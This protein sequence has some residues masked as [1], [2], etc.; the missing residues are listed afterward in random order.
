MGINPGRMSSHQ[1]FAKELG[2]SFPL[3]VDAD[4][5]VA[6]SYGALKEDGVGIQRTV[7]IVD[8]QGVVRYIKQG[9]PPD[10][11]LLEAIKAF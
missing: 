2:L 11:E 1:R 10:A 4:R 3:L 9:M 5:V 7:V 8:K 6:S